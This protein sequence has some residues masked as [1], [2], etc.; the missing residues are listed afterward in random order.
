MI[1]S[2]TAYTAEIDDFEIA[3]KEIKS[4]LNLDENMMKN[5][6]GI[7][8]CNYEFVVAGTVRAICKSLPFDVI[9][10]VT[11]TQGINGIE[12]LMILTVM[13]FTSDDVE[14]RA[15]ISET[16]RGNCEKSIT[17][18]YN[19]IN[20]INSINSENAESPELIISIAPYMIENSGDVYVETITKVSGGVPCF[21]TMAMDDSSDFAN[22]YVI[23]N[24]ENYRDRMGMILLCGNVNPKFYTANIS[25]NKIINQS[26]L[27][28]SSEGHVLKEVNDRPVMEFFEKLN[29]TKAAETSYA[30]SSLPFMLDYND[31]T[32]LVARIFVA[33]DENRNAICAGKM[34]QG[35]TLHIGVTDKDDI[36]LTTAKA[37]GDAFAENPGAQNMLIYSCL[38]RNMSLDG[39]IYA[40]I[41]HVGAMINAAGGETQYMIATSGG[42]ICPVAAASSVVNASAAA[43][44]NGNRIK[45]ENK[46]EDE[47]E[48]EKKA[49]DTNQKNKNAGKTVNRFHNNTFILCVF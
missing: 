32:P 49:N 47:K 14:F 35:A 48:N 42:E 10:S 1:K 26:A 9:G 11:T 27:I 36:L 41:K 19:K 24:G 13:M 2:Y 38:A 22:A 17:D 12:G 8:A 15:G 45:R 16:L 29:L 20:N 40:E 25:N 44:G 28:T 4:R 7:L 37:V 5:T 33:M 43:D 18:A 46:K 34:P 23:Y 39:D 3:V 6:V 30:M 21:G 31:G